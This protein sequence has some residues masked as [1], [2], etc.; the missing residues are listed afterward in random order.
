MSKKKTKERNRI[1][2]PVSPFP[3]R[4][5]SQ[6]TGV[7]NAPARGGAG[8]RGQADSSLAGR[9]PHVIYAGFRVIYVSYN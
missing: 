6:A 3:A 7:L 4:V 1:T 9:R 5:K 8:S 2:I